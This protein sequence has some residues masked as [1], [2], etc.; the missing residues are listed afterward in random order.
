MIV[1]YVDVIEFF[2]SLLIVCYRL[3]VP[4]NSHYFVS[5]ANFVC[6]QDVLSLSV[7]M[8]RKAHFLMDFINV[9]FWPLSMLPA[10]TAESLIYFKKLGVVLPVIVNV[11]GILLLAVI[12]PLGHACETLRQTFNT[13]PNSVP[14]F[15][16]QFAFL[17]TG[18][19]IICSMFSMLL[20]YTYFITQQILQYIMLTCQ[21]SLIGHDLMFVAEHQRHNSQFYQK[22]VRERLN[23]CVK[24]HIALLK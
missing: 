19:F 14:F 20:L 2:K 24:H 8:N 3:L 11:F 5:N 16:F 15:L 23:G 13:T 4:F 17:A 10:S 7:L 12:L 22:V 21:I 6:F 1:H 18:T 9:H